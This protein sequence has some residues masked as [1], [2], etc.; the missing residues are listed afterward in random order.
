L[1]GELGVDLLSGDAGNDTLNGGL[2][3]DTLIGGDGND[4]FLFNSKI[5]KTIDNIDTLEDFVSGVDKIQL[6]KSIFKGLA[7]G[8]ITDSQFYSAPGASTAIDSLNRIIYNESS[9]ALYFD[10]DGSG[11]K[12]DAIQIAIITGGAP[13]QDSDLWVI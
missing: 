4:I 8:Q 3:N 13:L 9:G 5:S 10:A 11:E 7:N 2:G 12:V 1:W 6:S